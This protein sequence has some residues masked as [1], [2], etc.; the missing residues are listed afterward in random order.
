MNLIIQE[1]NNYNKNS[2]VDSEQYIVIED[3]GSILNKKNKPLL[4]GYENKET[5]VNYLSSYIGMVLANEFEDLPTHKNSFKNE[6]KKIFNRVLNTLSE[7][8]EKIVFF[9][10]QMFYLFLMRKQS[11]KMEEHD[12][13]IDKDVES[14]ENIA[15]NRIIDKYNE[16]NNKNKIIKIEYL[17]ILIVF[18][19]NKNMKKALKE[20]GFY[21]L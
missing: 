21:D 1:E 4:S 2:I 9:D 16:T 7:K 11:F 6:M 13:I 19:P 14:I 8:K 17:D 15:A 3:N 20:L 18:F 5:A 12:F 10:I